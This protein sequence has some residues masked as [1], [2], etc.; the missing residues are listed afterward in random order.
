MVAQAKIA[1][2]E[3]EHPRGRGAEIQVGV[4]KNMRSAEV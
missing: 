2:G 3:I 1:C 4:P